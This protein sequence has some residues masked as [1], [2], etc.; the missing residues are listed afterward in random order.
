MF[1]ANSQAQ[2]VKGNTVVWSDNA[3]KVQR[4]IYLNQS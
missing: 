4:G 2:V 3:E 1:A